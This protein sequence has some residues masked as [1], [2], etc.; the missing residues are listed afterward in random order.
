MTN[1]VRKESN[2]DDRHLFFCGALYRGDGWIIAMIM[3]CNEQWRWLKVEKEVQSQK[4]EII[5][6]YALSW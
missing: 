3:L 4:T 1:T 5:I 2:E 6:N